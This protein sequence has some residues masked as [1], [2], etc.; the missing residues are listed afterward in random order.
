MSES[1]PSFDRGKPEG[2]L[3]VAFKS[4]VPLY[5]GPIAKL[6][7]SRCLLKLTTKGRKSGQP[8]TVMIS[9]MPLDGGYIVFSGWGIKSN[10][11]QNVLANPDVT[12]NVGGKTMHATALLV[13]DGARRKELM[14]MHR[15]RS[16]RCGPPVFIRPVLKAL[17]L[18]D[19]DGDIELAASQGEALPVVQITPK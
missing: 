7:A 19:Y 15:E 6:M 4:P 1:T 11:Y 14:Q 12:L 3:K 5:V 9:F 2:L 18:F 16:R 13:E 8:R 17:R 10:W